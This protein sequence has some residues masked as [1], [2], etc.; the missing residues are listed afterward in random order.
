MASQLAYMIAS[1]ARTVGKTF[2]RSVYSDRRTAA[3]S[4]ASSNMPF[5][6]TSSGLAGTGTLPNTPLPNL[7]LNRVYVIA[8]AGTC[9]AS[10]SV[11]NGLRGVDVEVI[12]LGSSTCGKPYG[13][14]ARDNCGLSYFPVEFKGVNAKGFGDFADGFAP[15]CAVAD[16]LD[17]PLGAES[18]GMLAAALAYRNGAS[19]AG[20]ASANGSTKD[21]V[22]GRGGVFDGSVV[23][24]AERNN[25]FLLP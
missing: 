5:I 20:I 16:D 19:C 12:V 13:F 10:E 15:T 18:E 9:S 24:P 17:H 14:T 6:G 1:P 7:G 25:K 23:R 3:T 8:S 21:D 4:S 22:A 11:I 2:E